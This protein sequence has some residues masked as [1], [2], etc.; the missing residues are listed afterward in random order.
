MNKRAQLA[1]GG[2]GL[3]RGRIVNSQ[4]AMIS[5]ATELNPYLI[6]SGFLDDAPFSLVNFIFRYG[7]RFSTVADIDPVDTKNDELP[8]AAEVPLDQLRVSNVEDVK[9]AFA[10]V[11]IPAL[12]AVATLYDLPQEGIRRFC[13]EYGY[14]MQLTNRSCPDTGIACP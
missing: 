4:K 13:A 11:L 9:R 7:D 8:V 5:L 14:E 3:K 2:V 10:S 6:E 12:R 1:V